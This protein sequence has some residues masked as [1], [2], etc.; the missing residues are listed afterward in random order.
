MKQIIS[1]NFIESL[2]KYENM[3]RDEVKVGYPRPSV[4][5][6]DSKATVAD[7]AMWNEFG[8]PGRIPARLFFRTA[9]NSF[10]AGMKGVL[11]KSIDAFKKGK[12][13]KPL[14]FAAIMFVDEVQNQITAGSWVPN[15]PAT[16]AKKG[17]SRPLMDTGK[18]AQSVQ[19]W[20]D[21]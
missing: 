6:P 12:Y 2:R 19:V 4:P 13:A 10:K 20:R 8:V 11:E 9:W 18:L 21:A 5:Y 16:I 7:V 17:S 15:N 3:F 14:E 1:K